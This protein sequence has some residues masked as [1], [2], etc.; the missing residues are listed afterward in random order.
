MLS[1]IKTEKFSPRYLRLFVFHGSSEMSR[2]IDLSLS[3]CG[4]TLASPKWVSKYALR[5]HNRKVQPPI[6]TSFHFSR[7]V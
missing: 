1:D 5:F 6:S 4:A 3:A 7:I 2:E